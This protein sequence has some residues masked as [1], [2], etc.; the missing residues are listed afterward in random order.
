[1]ADYFVGVVFIGFFL[2]S[3]CRSLYLLLR[4][5]PTMGTITELVRDD[6]GD[7][8]AYHPVVTF[9]TLTGTA[10]VAKSSFGASEAN[11]YF[12]IGQ[13]VPIRYS[14]KN[15]QFFAI[16]GYDGS[17]VFYAGLAAAFMLALLWASRHR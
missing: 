6:S 7:G 9:T 14:A 15:P 13:Q 1:M 8:V 12:H 16:K 11:T 4:G 17:A 2:W 10:V 5:V 3:T